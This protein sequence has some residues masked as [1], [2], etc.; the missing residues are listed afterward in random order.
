[1]GRFDEL[2]G[3]LEEK[4]GAVTPYLDERQRRVL[5]AAEARQLGHGGIA[6]VA[7]AA[8]VSKGCVSRGL[9]E[10]DA[11]RAPDG[12]VRRP[13]AGRPALSEKDPGLVPALLALVEDTTQGDPIGPLTWTTKSLRRLADE[14][15]AQGRKVGRDTVAALLKAAGFSLRGNARVLA[16]SH[17][18]DRDAQFRPINDT[19]KTFLDGGDPVI[20]VDTKKKEQIGLF[21]QAGREWRPPGAPVKV[22]D[23]DFPTH[24]TGTA[25]PYG[26][27]DV[28]RN[29][30][31]V[32][33]GTDH[34]TAAFAVACLRRWWKEEGRSAHPSATRLLIT[35]DG[36][37]SNSSRAKTWKANLAL[38]ASETG[39]EI[40]VCH[41]P[42]GTSK[43]NRVEHRL[44]SFISMN[45]RA[46]P[47][48]SYDV[49][50][51]LIS[52][53]TT[54]TG[55]T[56][57][58]RLDT[59]SYPTGIEISQQHAAALTIHP[60][61]FHGEWNYTIPPQPGIPDVPLHPPGPRSHPRHAHT[62]GATLATHPLLTGLD[63]HDLDRLT[64][65]IRDR[66]DALPPKQ[67]PRHRKLTTENIIWA[68]VLDQR[69]LSCSLTAYLFRIGENQMRALIKQVRPLLEDHGHRPEP[70]PARLI[71]PSDLASYVMHATSQASEHDT[72]H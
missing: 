17:H 66:L 61:A 32:V 24:A 42:P 71:D 4:F 8:G 49:A 5:Y 39:L 44:F 20:S 21:G 40:K 37:G 62:F 19:V 65:D 48:T 16:G 3:S 45:W 43:W 9:A 22:L 72:T 34:D 38:L 41:L 1:M 63:R 50:L 11:G 30:G 33:I 52:S 67:R 56:V 26:I 68:T 54:R 28:A 46:R 69:G 70:I 25:I 53:T 64:A 2:I 7:R 18:P 36:G 35:A 57:T 10:L 51:N 60:D 6:A 58:A 15:A 55:L 27:Y 47:L 59:S 14:L 29:T 13:G 31:Y 23:H 12:R